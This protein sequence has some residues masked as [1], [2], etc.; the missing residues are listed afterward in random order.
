MSAAGISLQKLYF[1]GTKLAA[2]RYLS[3]TSKGDDYG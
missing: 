3:I 2:L 1:A